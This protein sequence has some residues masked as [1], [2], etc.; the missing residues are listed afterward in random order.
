MSR[1]RRN[2]IKEPMGYVA[3]A[4]VPMLMTFDEDH[5][6]FIAKHLGDALEQSYNIIDMFGEYDDDFDP[7]E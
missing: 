7:F 2:N 1:R 5:V 3:V 6:N 4:Q